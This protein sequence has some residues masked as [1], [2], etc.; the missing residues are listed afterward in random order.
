MRMSNLVVHRFVRRVPRPRRRGDALARLT[1]LLALV[2]SAGSALAATGQA[3]PEPSAAPA[4]RAGKLLLTG[5]VS[6]IDGAAG[7][8]LTP[9]ALTGTYAT[10]GQFGASA[11][12]TRLRTADYGL[13]VAGVALGYG[14]RVELS[15]AR[16]SFDT[17]PTGTALGLPGLRLAQDIVGAKFRVVGDAVL[18]SDRWLPQ[19]A[20]GVLRKSLDAQGLAPTLAALGARDSGTDVYVSA[21][22]LFLAQ[23]LLANLTLRSTHANQ[24]GLLGFGGDGHRGRTIQPEISLAWLLSRHVAIGAEYR[25][26]PDNLNPSP[27]GAGLEEDDWHDVFIAWAPAKAVSLT[28]AWVDLGRVVPAVVDRRQRGAYLSVQLAL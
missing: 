8:G 5:G 2:A 16:Q 23:G 13:T 28:L 18:D 15:L 12:A 17:G 4:G 25:A 7:G 21:S 10:D 24:N 26:K 6:S 1:A 20:V 3:A 14:D 9:W 19:I 27:L 11:F 22:K